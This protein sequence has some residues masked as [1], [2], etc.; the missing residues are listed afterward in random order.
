MLVAAFFAGGGPAELLHT[1]HHLLAAG[2]GIGQV[3]L[4]LLA[5]Q[6][7]RVPRPFI[8]DAE[9]GA[10]QPP[11]RAMRLEAASSAVLGDQMSQFMLQRSL[12]LAFVI[13]QARHQLNAPVRVMPTAGSYDQPV[14]TLH[15]LPS[16]PPRLSRSL[17]P[18]FLFSYPIPI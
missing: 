16:P 17:Q 10:G 2:A 18:Y 14:I 11:L 6:R 3:A 7:Q 12:H 8:R 9:I 1:P 4:H 5:R 13:N 15:T